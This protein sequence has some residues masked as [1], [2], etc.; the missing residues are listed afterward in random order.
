MKKKVLDITGYKC[1]VTF[2]KAREFIKDNCEMQKI[3]LIK[4][5]KDCEKLKNSLEKNFQIK[6]E[7]V[8]KNI[9]KLIF[10]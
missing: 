8:D 7:K 1:P 3:I 6:I 2:I 4:G 10:T 9:F 5:K